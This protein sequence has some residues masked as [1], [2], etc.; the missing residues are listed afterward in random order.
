M[1][2][3]D[4]TNLVREYVEVEKQLQKLKEL[5]TK[6][7]N[8]KKAIT[9]EMEKRTLDRFNYCGR[10]ITYIKEYVRPA[11]EVPETTI[12]PSVRIQGGTR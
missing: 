10:Y 5:E 9:K 4:L 1:E 6:K 7:N 8:L 2:H 11:Y 12:A 3:K